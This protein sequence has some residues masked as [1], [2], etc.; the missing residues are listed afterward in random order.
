MTLG[1]VLHAEVIAEIDTLVGTD[2]IDDWDVEAIETAARRQTM[3]VAARAVEQPINADTSDHAGPTVPCGCGQ[4]ARYAGRRDKTVASVLGLLTLSRAYDHC[5]VCET[6][7][8]PRDRALGVQR[9]SL[10]PGALRMVGRVGA[11]VSYWAAIESAATCDTDE[12]PAECVQRLVRE[13]TRRG[14]EQ[15][16]RRVVLGDGALWIWSLTNEHFPGAI[17]IVDLYH[18][19]GHLWD[20]AKAKYCSF[21]DPHMLGDIRDRCQRRRVSP[22][23]KTAH[24]PFHPTRVAA[25]PARHHSFI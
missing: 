25:P 15:A 1:A 13:A 22:E 5:A 8:C 3:W 17:P 2:A 24:F 23:G 18:A 20:V 4:P 12:H 10:M 16:G 9:G 21:N 14:V 19:M 11:M 6:G 7:L